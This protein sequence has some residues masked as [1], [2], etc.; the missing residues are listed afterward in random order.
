M[1]KERIGSLIHNAR[2]RLWLIGSGLDAKGAAEIQAVSSQLASAMAL[3][4]LDALEQGIQSQEVDLGCFVSD[5]MA[6]AASLAPA[7]LSTVDNSDLASC[8]SSS[9]N[10]DIELI[11]LALI[12]ALA[13]AWR[14]ARTQVSFEVACREGELQFVIQDD[15]P[16]YPAPWLEICGNLDG[17][18]PPARG[19]GHGLHL[20]WRIAQM[21]SFAGRRG[22]IELANNT[23][24]GG[25]RFCLTLP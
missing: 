4:R 9:W 24:T 22:R 23:P 7:H 15:G 6:E 3:L 14:H 5:L 16:G 25:A 13:N 20:A 17:P 8:P 11:R 18:R 19:T 1:S 10:F 12:D 21:H 2:N